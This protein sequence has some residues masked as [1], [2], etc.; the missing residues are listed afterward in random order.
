MPNAH[1]VLFRTLADPTR[2]AIFERLCRDGEQTVGALTAHAGI[3]QPAV[4]KHLGLLKQAGLVRDRHE[5]RRTHY[6]AQA[7]AL[8]PL[9]GWAGQMHGFWETRFD[10]LEDLLKRMDQ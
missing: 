10:N 8:A 7:G 5:G 4:S 2:R 9:I 1:D 6:S 3:S